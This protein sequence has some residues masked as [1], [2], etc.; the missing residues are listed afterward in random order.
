MDNPRDLEDRL[1]DFAVRI[2]NP[3]VGR[4]LD[5]PTYL[6]EG[7]PCATVDG[8]VVRPAVRRVGW[9]GDPPTALGAPAIGVR[10]AAKAPIWRIVLLAWLA[11]AWVRPLAAEITFTDITAETGITF[12]H[13]DGGSGRRYIIEYVSG[14]LALFDYD[15]DGDID[16]YFLNGAPH[17]GTEVTTP[18][19]NALY[20]NDGGWRFTDVT[21]SAGVADAGHGLGVTVGDYDNDGDQDLYVNNAGPNRLY[22]NNADGT[23]SD[24]TAQAGVGNGDRVGAG[25]CFLDYDADG[26]LDLYVANY[27]R[28][29]YDKHIVRTK[30]GYPIYVSPRDYEPEPDSLF[31]NNGDGTFTDVSD[32]SGIADKAGPGMGCICADYDADG[33]TDIFVANDVHANFLFQNDGHGRF[34]EEGLFRGFAYD[35]RG[36]VHGSMGVD[37]GDYDNDGRLDFHVTSYQQELATLYRNVKNDLL[38]D[39]TTASGIGIGTRSQVTWGNAFVDVDNDGD[40]DVFIACGHLY[41]NVEH[42]DSTATYRAENLLFANLGQ[43]QFKNVSRKSGNGLLVKESSR[44]AAFDDL[45]GDGDLDGVVLNARAAPTLLRNDTVTDHHWIGLRLR[46]VTANADGVGARVEITA[47]GRRQIQEVHSGRG[48]QGHFGS[49]LHFGLGRATQVERVRVR[50]IGGGTQTISEPLSVDRIHTI[51]ERK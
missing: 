50:W 21:E 15:R 22:R 42:F 43:G 10:S 38:V 9:S 5:R 23:F 17:P 4:S 8:R 1:I 24:V 32:A 37:C 6:T 33:D 45:D 12:R 48:Y 41:D 29:T 11:S 2:I 27:I 36:T 40:L 3:A 46:G 39:V 16:I 34:R 47:D 14:G 28:F 19:T 35:Q 51:V 26:D 49:T 25:A 7:L 20:R 30:Q 44:G 31:R 13:T 18:P